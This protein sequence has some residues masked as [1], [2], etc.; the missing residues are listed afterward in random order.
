MIVNPIANSGNFEVV[1]I[2]TTYRDNN[3]FV[4]SVY[5]TPPSSA[6]EYTPNELIEYIKLAI[7]AIIEEDDT[8]IVILGGDLNQ[9]SHTAL[10]EMGFISLVKE[11]THCGHYLDRLYTT[12]PLYSMTKVVL[13]TVTTK[14]RAIVAAADI[15]SLVD[16]NKVNPT[17]KV[18]MIKPARNAVALNKM[19]DIDW[20]S[21]N[22]ETVLQRSYD[23]IYSQLGSVLETCYPLSSVTVSN[24]DPVLVTPRIKILLRQKNKLMQSGRI[25]KANQITERLRY[26]IVQ[27]NSTE[28]SDKSVKNLNDLWAAVQRITGRGIVK[29]RSSCLLNY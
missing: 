16:R 20:S 26:E 28:L 17:V 29:P 11:P 7:G 3:L 27:Y 18:R 2:Q 24:K 9:L 22:N 5:H 4:A 6:C 14:H 21:I 1:W 15:L 12:L 25:E 8:A 10:L 19:N 13:S 23:S